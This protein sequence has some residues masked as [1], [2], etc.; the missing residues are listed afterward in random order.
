MDVELTA[1]SEMDKPVLANLIQLYV[2]DFSEFQGNE[3][4]SHGTFVYSYLDSYFT[5]PNR[6]PWFI[7]VDGNLA[8]FALARG[9]VDDD[10][11]WNIGEFFVVRKYRRH[12]VA[13]AAAT[14]LFATH[15]GVWTLS[16]DRANA[17]ASALWPA[18]AESVAVGEIGRL[19]LDHPEVNYIRTR[20]RFR[21]L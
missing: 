12:G 13:R 19:D 20:L 16:F 9:D 17:P 14:K 11:S 7:T 8:G 2:Y 6:E 4:T 21:V 10:G 18:V 3:L 5:E 15:P 1:V